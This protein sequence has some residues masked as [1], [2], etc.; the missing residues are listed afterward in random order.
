MRERHSESRSNLDLDTWEYLRKAS[1]AALQSFEVSR[2]S[3]AAFLL[4]ECKSMLEQY[5]KET[6][7]AALA[8]TLSRCHQ[9]IAD[10]R[11]GARPLVHDQQPFPPPIPAR[12]A[13]AFVSQIQFLPSPLNRGSGGNA[14][15]PS[16]E[17]FIA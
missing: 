5:A 15:L 4:A 13:M 8:R 2:L 11:L 16:T 10:V 17:F 9:H 1:T 12:P 6:A 7:T 3:H 14:D